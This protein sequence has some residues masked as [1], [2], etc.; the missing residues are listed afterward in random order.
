MGRN[1]G[2][3]QQDGSSLSHMVSARGAGAVGHT[4]K[5]PSPHPY[6]CLMIWLDGCAHRV[7]CTLHIRQ[8]FSTW[9]REVILLT[10]QFRVPKTS[11]PR[12]RKW[13]LPGLRN[14]HSGSSIIFY[15][16]SSHR[17]HPGS[18]GEN[19]EPKFSVGGVWKLVPSS[20][21]YSLWSET[22]SS[23]WKKQMKMMQKRW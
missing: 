23:L 21:C 13:K 3:A 8:G 17:A 12:H 10:W 7:H 22:L 11:I 4:S 18:R 1:S 20:M 9:S 19:L 2:R 15:W 6:W 5:L 14:W 16:S